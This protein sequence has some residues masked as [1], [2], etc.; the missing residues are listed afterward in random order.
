MIDP[1]KANGRPQ[2]AND[3]PQK[4][5]G[6]PQ[7]KQLED[8]KKQMEDPKKQMKDSKKQT[9]DPKKQ[10]KDSK[11]QMQDP[12]KQ[13]EGKERS[14]SEHLPPAAGEG[15]SKKRLWG[16]CR[17]GGAMWGC[18]GQLGAGSCLASGFGFGRGSAQPLC[19]ERKVA[20]PAA[21]WR[22]GARTQCWLI[23]YFPFLYGKKKKGKK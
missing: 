6:R 3:R 12:K 8:P 15:Q 9:Q 18:S 20:A 5:N 16:L 7:K 14:H 19:S 22:F 11:K 13:M 17:A 1:H 2:K 21:G 23:N 4:A 10:M